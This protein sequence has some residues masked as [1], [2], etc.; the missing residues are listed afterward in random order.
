MWSPGRTVVILKPDHSFPR[1]TGRAEAEDGRQQLRQLHRRYACFMA[2][3]MVTIGPQS[4]HKS[5]G[6]HALSSLY[7]RP[8]RVEAHAVHVA[9]VDHLDELSL[10]M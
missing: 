2:D 9:I 7:T 4:Q 6:R 8:T 10:H 1:R 3:G 5:T